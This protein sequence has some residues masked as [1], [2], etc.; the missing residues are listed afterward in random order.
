MCVLRCL[1]KLAERGNILPQNRQVYLA[2]ALA[3]EDVETGTAELEEAE[4]ALEGKRSMGVGLAIPV[5]PA[6][7]G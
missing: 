4:H 2:L 5:A 3:D 1:V 7:K 6:K